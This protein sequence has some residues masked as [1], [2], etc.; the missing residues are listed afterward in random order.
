MF[1]ERAARRSLARF[2][3]K[4]PDALERRMLQAA[5]EGGVAGA[6]VLE[7]GGGI[8]ALQSELLAAGAASGEIVEVVPVYQ[9]Y[10]QE[11][12]RERGQEARVAFR[13]VDV[14]EQPD[15]VEPADVVLLNRVVC[16]SPDGVALAAAAARLARR[17]LVLSFP[18]DAAWVRLGV[19]LLNAGLWAL[20]RSFRTFVH[21]PAAL[22][23]AI[24]AEGLRVAARGTD[25]PWE[26]VAVR[27]A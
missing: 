20:R 17:T 24:E 25:G 27:R 4:G 11:L 14:L 16:C 9:R 23:A 10:A 6:R 1:T 12:A 21:P 7:I 18:R 15:A 8:G 26:F 2:R 19:R 5:S 13:V 3:K 22:R